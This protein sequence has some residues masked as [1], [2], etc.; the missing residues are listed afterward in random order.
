MKKIENLKIKIFSDGANEKDML[1]MNS[2]SIIKGLTTNPSLMKKAGINDYK[3]FAKKILT[4]IKNKPVSFEIFSDE[5][6]EMEKQALEINSWGENIY[7]KIPISNTM[8]VSTA[9]LLKKLSIKKVKLNVTAIMTVDQVKEVMNVLKKDVPSIISVF[10]GRIADTGRDPVPIMKNC[11]KEMENNP[12]SELLWAS[13]REL[14]NIFQANDI[15]CHIITVPIDI[16][17]KLNLIDY[18]LNKYS[19]DTVKDFYEDALKAK[20]EI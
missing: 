19:L 4:N 8:N 18:D 5:I 15:G 17:N 10:A 20:F 7:V 16:L 3:S 12:K 1:E 11:L 6:N 9:G 14:F 13:T 2:K